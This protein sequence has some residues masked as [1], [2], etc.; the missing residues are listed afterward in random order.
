[1]KVIGAISS[2]VI[3]AASPVLAA[4]MAVKARPPAPAPISLWEVEIGA[5]YFYSNGGY[6]YNL[7][8]AAT[9]GQ[10]NSRLT[11][12]EDGHAGEGFWRADHTSGFF[13]KGYGG[14]GV[15]RNGKLN[16]EDFPPAIPTYSNTLSV[17]DGNLGYFT[18]DVGYAFYKSQDARVGVFAGYN[19]YHERTNASGCQQVVGNFVC[20]VPIPN[21]VLGIV[22]DTNW[23]SARFGIVGEKWFGNWKLTGEAAALYTTLSAVDSHVLAFP[24]DRPQDADGWGVQLEALAQY[25]VTPNFSLGVGGRYWYYEADGHHTFNIPPA[26]FTPRGEFF[27]ERYGV[28]FQAAYKFG[29]GGPVV[30]KY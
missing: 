29:G 19:Y 22:Q 18:A 16:D 7:Y 21:N 5:R 14:W 28:F 17:V 8:S 27:S 25:F 9:P 6:K 11:Y 12:K 23:H 3:L 30:A 24:V 20:P 1:M 4:D 2:L 10:L 15:L 26:V 13:F